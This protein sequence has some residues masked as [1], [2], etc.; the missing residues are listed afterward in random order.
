[1]REKSVNKSEDL[2][3]AVS[4]SKHV[5][6]KAK[7]VQDKDKGGLTPSLN[8]E[9]KA[10]LN[11]YEATI[12]KG[13]DT[14]FEVGRAFAEISERGLY[15]EN[16]T[17]F[18]DYCREVWNVSRSKAYRYI[19]ASK[20]V[21]NLQ[22][23]Q[24]ATQEE[25][26][27]PTS[28]AQARKIAKISPANQ[29]KVAKKVAQ[30]ASKPTAKDFDEEVDK[31]NDEETP[32][33]KSYDIR[34]EAGPDEE[35]QVVTKTVNVAVLIKPDAALITHQELHALSVNAYNLFSNSTKKQEVEKILYKIQAGL[36]E[37]A[38]W[39]ANHQTEQEAA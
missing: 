26:A 14:F 9:E 39:E 33:V 7:S 10:L 22:C 23:S 5:P 28:E 35:N 37:W 21:E 6:A 25:L 17:S 38:E 4:T 36:R 27:I 1:M 20:C 24:M 12:K 16:H 34:D 29:V 19:A 3:S 32:R 30:K 13:L 31:L 11:E 2:D 15:R 8:A 18:E